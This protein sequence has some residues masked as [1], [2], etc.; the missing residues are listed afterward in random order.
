MISS[1][2]LQAILPLIAKHGNLFD[3]KR[4]L[5]L[6]IRDDKK[7]CCLFWKQGDVFDLYDMCVTVKDNLLLDIE[8]ILTWINA[9]DGSQL[10]HFEFMD[11]LKIAWGLQKEGNKWIAKS[12]QHEDATQPWEEIS[13][14]LCHFDHNGTM[15]N[16]SDNENEYAR[17]WK[18]AKELFSGKVTESVAVSVIDFVTVHGLTTELFVRRSNSNTSPCL[19]YGIGQNLLLEVYLA[20]NKVV[21]YSQDVP[22]KLTLPVNLK[23]AYLEIQKEL[24]KQKAI[25]E[26]IAK[27]KN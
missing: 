26:R 7:H 11:D 22:E 8:N 25:E 2:T 27:V 14:F 19:R 17:K 5:N 4:V 23:K 18:S 21:L 16:I 15:K 20:K 9:P 10:L 12:C 6:L 1:Q 24:R 3:F 13:K